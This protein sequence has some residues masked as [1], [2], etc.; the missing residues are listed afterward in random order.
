MAFAQFVLA[1]AH[2]AGMNTMDGINLVTNGAYLHVLIAAL[3][4]L[5]DVPGLGALLQSA[6]EKIML[7]LAITQKE[8]TTRMLNMGVRYCLECRADRSDTD[9]FSI[10]L[11][12]LR[13]S[14]SLSPPSSALACSEQL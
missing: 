13:L 14:S 8:T 2:D 5:V 4:I 7:G 3:S 1:A 9:P 10:V 6:P 12:I 11:Q